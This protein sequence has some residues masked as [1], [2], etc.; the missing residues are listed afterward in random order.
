MYRFRLLRTLLVV[1]AAIL[2]SCATREV[3]TQP[4]QS[5]DEYLSNA[6]DWIETHA[7]FSGT[8]SW[9]IIRNEAL[10][11]D[12]QTIADTYRVLCFA[13]RS[14]RDSNAWLWV[15]DELKHDYIGF[16]YI[17]NVV[18]M[19]DPDGPAEQAGVRVGDIIEDQSPRSSG[20]PPCSE[21]KEESTQVHLTVRRA[22]QA[23]PIE[24]IID[25]VADP[26]FD[27]GGKP[28]GRRLETNLGAVGYLELPYDTGAY[29]SYPG[30]VRQVMRKIDRR[31]VC[32]WIIDLRRTE[33]GDIW[34]YLAALGPILGEGDVGGFLYL[35]KTREL[36]TYRDGQVFWDGERRGESFVEGGIY[37]PKRA[38]PPVALLIGGGTMAAGELVLVAFQGY[39][40]VRTFGEPTS[41]APRLILHTELSDGT[42]IFVSGAL[43]IDR[44]GRPYT[45][46]LR[47]DEYVR[48]DWT[49][50]DTD[51]DR[52]LNAAIDWLQTQPE[53]TP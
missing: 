6:L 28:A 23:E 29:R 49:Q 38:M 9:T 46:Y 10:A 8:V 7:V 20:T 52:V 40:H 24:I 18:I 43:A 42:W 51:Q 36:W 37:Q 25:K 3:P 31:P 13:L 48:T 19:V 22:G 12:P 4:P 50:F 33:G 16:D 45:G 2:S 32:G 1:L 47:P 39:P 15:P 5:P 53:C 34:T 21:E 27:V 44:S 26:G 35:D 14:L 41:G 30:V 11:A 17:D